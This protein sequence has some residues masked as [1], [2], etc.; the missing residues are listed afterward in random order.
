MSG[1]T[2]EGL[3]EKIRNSKFILSEDES[4]DLFFL[5]PNLVELSWNKG[6]VTRAKINGLNLEFSIIYQNKAFS[7]SSHFHPS[8]KIEKSFKANCFPIYS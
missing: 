3:R 5:F 8:F 2:V 6:N 4:I 1:L 7:F